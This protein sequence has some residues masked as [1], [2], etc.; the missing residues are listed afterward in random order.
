MVT[1][2]SY[3]LEFF[4]AVSYIIMLCEMLFFTKADLKCHK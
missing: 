3:K 2:S 1:L 4:V